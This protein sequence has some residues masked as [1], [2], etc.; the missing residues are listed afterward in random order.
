MKHAK[1]I[2]LLVFLVV[3]SLS[4][5]SDSDANQAI[6]E[7]GTSEGV[8][9]SCF[10]YKMDQWYASFEKYQAAGYSMAV[11][12]RKAVFDAV[13]ACKTCMEK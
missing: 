8:S 4:S 3:V 1:Y 6:A 11:A 12:D 5:C 10:D 9:V 2:Y 13:Q 7:F